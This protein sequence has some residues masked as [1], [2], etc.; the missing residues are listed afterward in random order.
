MK[1]LYTLCF[2]LI[3]SSLLAQD[4]NRGGISARLNQQLDEQT[5]GY[6]HISILLADRL[7]VRAL[8][9]DLYSRRASR[10]ERA[11]ELVTSLKTQAENT[12]DEL[13][14]FLATQPGVDQS[15]IHTYWITNLIF[16]RADRE[17]V[18][19]LS[20]RNDVE[21]LD[22]NA[23]LAQTD[24][25][26]V[27]APAPMPPN[28]SEPGLKAINAPA[29]WA[30]GYTGYGK[31]AFANDT[32]VDPI[33]PSFRLKYRGFY[34]PAEQAWYEFESENLI[35]YDCS[36]HG[37]H[38]LGT[39]IGLDRNTNDT[40]GVAF[41]ALW[42]GSP[43]LCGIGTEDNIA[44]FQWALDPDG[45]AATFI[46]MPSVINNS[47]YDPSL[48]EEDCVSIYV[49][50]LDALEASGIAVIFS[51]GN[52]GPGTATITPPHNINTDLVNSMTVGAL[53]GSSSTFAIADFSS[54]GPSGCGGLESLL[55]KPEVSAP[56]VSVRSAELDGTYGLKSGTS[57]AGPH[58]AGAIMLLQEAFPDL[59]GTELKLAVYFTCIDLG[60]IGEDNTYGMGII[61]VLAAF[62]YL[63]DQGNE[64]ANPIVA[65]DI[66]LI[67]AQVSDFICDESTILFAKVENGGTETITSFL[68]TYGVEGLTPISTTYEWEGTLEP[69]GRALLSLPALT[70]IDPGPQEVSIV[71]S[72]PNGIQD[73]RIL[74]NVYRQSIIGLSAQNF[75]ALVEQEAP[76][77]GGS[78]T[79][80]AD[81]EGN[82]DILW[83]D[84]ESGGMPIGI[85]EVIEIDNLVE[86]TT[87]FVDINQREIT[88]VVD[89]VE[90]DLVYTADTD[91]GFTFD[92][93]H[94]FL[95]K[96]ARFF[97]EEVGLVQVTLKDADDEILISRVIF[98]NNVGEKILPLN[99]EVPQQNGL[100][101]TIHSGVSGKHTP[102]GAVYPF[103]VD[104]LLSINGAISDGGPA[105][106]YYYFYDLEIEFNRLCGRIPLTVEV[107][108]DGNAPEASFSPST[109]EVN[110]DENEEVIFTDN[111]VGAIT[112]LWNFGDGTTSDLQNPMHTYSDTGSYFVTLTITNLEGCFDATVETIH[113]SGTIVSTQSPLLAKAVQ[114]FPNPAKNRLVVEFDLAESQEIEIQLLDI[115]GREVKRI[116][117]KNYLNDRVALSI[118]DLSNGVYFIR[119][120][121]EKDQLTKK[122]V[123]SE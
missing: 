6:H 52:A 104:E 105:D 47:W 36:D 46:D 123:K 13:L 11:Y 109:T 35:P 88:G 41:N 22:I 79:L 84:Q 8:D 78:A 118:G 63:V 100:K 112:W 74:N 54:R 97:V 83:Y 10:Q 51:A 120:E 106:A 102:S 94:P 87:Y 48:Q 26:D 40:I 57:M 82:G 14:D 23:Q 59:T 73:D 114:I 93:Y 9:A 32:G 70:G 49:P 44:A 116:E 56:G 20:Q 17:V 42:V 65:R 1:L 86:T 5:T 7:D 38:T 39:M 12:Q 101:L 96:S 58:V 50:T 77:P 122:I 33:H 25:E 66:M 43:I 19:Q 3:F 60:E 69:G 113:V 16:V 24:Y 61:D 18:A 15:S 107:N 89:P 99:M 92:C 21:W 67:D 111:S 95:L 29:L 30:M 34:T 62:N 2:T 31:T 85:G 80:R 98:I 117:R 45:D 75:S 81:F 4:F 55:I 68:V 37:T 119:L 91:G 76:C 121:S 110:L 90:D 71:L 28:G 103:V 72:Q 64:P 108:P 53:D 115:L 27:A